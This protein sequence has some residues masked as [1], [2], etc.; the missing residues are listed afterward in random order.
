MSGSR[1]A[2]DF[3]TTN[4]VVAEWNESTGSAQTV[5]LRGLSAPSR[6]LQPASIPSLV[7]FYDGHRDDVRIGYAVRQ[8]GLDNPY[9]EAAQWLFANF[10]EALVGK[11]PHPPLR[12]RDGEVTAGQAAEIFLDR[13]VSAIKQSGRTVAELVLTAP[14]GAF[15]TYLRWL[16]RMAEHLGVPRI[17][18]LDEPTAAAFG[19]KLDAPGAIVLVVDFGGGTLDLSLVRLPGRGAHELEGILWHFGEGYQPG[20][21]DEASVT[22][23]VIAKEFLR[24]GGSDI[25]EWIVDD[26]LAR[27][28]LDRS[29]ARRTR[30]LALKMHAE[31]VKIGLSTSE[32]EVFQFFHD[33]LNRLLR[34]VYTRNDFEEILRH[35]GFESI[36]KRGFDSLFRQAEHAHIGEGQIDAVLLVGGSTLIPLVQELIKERFGERKVRLD[37][38]FEV[39]S[40]GALN[41]VSNWQL[42]DVLYHTY[43]LQYVDASSRDRRQWRY[44]YH[45]FIP[46]GTTYPFNRARPV[47]RYLRAPRD[48]SRWI[49]I[50]I[51]EVEEGTRAGSRQVFDRTGKLVRV[52]QNVPREQRV[53]LL[54]VPGGEIVVP[55]EPPGRK[56]EDRLEVEFTVDANRTL[57]IS[58]RD[59]RTGRKLLTNKAVA[60]LE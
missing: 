31:R 36:L 46:A 15:E 39:V 26:V 4:T 44:Q 6:G 14:V 21:A 8:Q 55:L 7:Y 42:Q 17:R 19:Y 56:G 49:E 29:V 34:V 16:S 48:G 22:G 1:I 47:T 60:E 52:D 40:H 30:H 41:L 51:A 58:I 50:V 54:N 18:L 45:P 33:E 20:I 2:I 53:T 28:G 9:G 59:L 5:V 32:R 10:K 25:D 38:P 3:G 13:I 12:L 24:L 11:R 23:R 27:H 37:R 43:A 57:R 35:H